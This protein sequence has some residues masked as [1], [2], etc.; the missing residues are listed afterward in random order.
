MQ[1]AIICIEIVSSVKRRLGV[2]HIPILELYACWNVLY[3]R[4][5][6]CSFPTKCLIVAMTPCSWIPLIVSRAPMA[7]SA[8]SAP[9]PS[10]LRPPLGFRPIGPTVGPSKMLTPLPR[11]SLPM[12]T[13]RWYIKSLSKVAPAVMPSGKAVTWSDWRMPLAP[14]SRQST[15]NPTRSAEPV[16]PLHRLA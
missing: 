16:F 11:A 8:G 1:C 12:A 14:S 5:I 3:M 2:I 4:Y 10:Q 15:G 6:S 13:A 7:W 9:K